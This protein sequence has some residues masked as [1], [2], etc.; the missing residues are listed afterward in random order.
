[1]SDTNTIIE[2]DHITKRYPKAKEF[3]LN[4]INL[5]VHKGEFF[6][7][8]GPNGCGKTTLISILCGLMPA[9][10]G[11]ITIAGKTIPGK[12]SAIKPLVGLVPQEIALYPTLTFRENLHFFGR[13]YGL[14]SKILKQRTQECLAIAG[15][16]QFADKRIKSYSGGM[17]RR[18]NLAISL[19]HKPQVLFLD[20]P[21][22]QI[23]PQSRNM[24]FKILGELNA[25]GT[26]L[27]YTTHY[28]EEAQQMCDRVAIVDKGLVICTDTP[29]RLIANTPGSKDLGEVFLHLTGKDLRDEQE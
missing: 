23:D 20:E 3:A 2:I 5:Q 13:L 14:T 24:I 22:V 21:T 4:G 26:T 18:A 29:Q 25:T 28:L 1:M 12:L 27:V 17:K 19:I 15:L 6:G 9:T 8:L 11:H 16:E 10:Q 7:L